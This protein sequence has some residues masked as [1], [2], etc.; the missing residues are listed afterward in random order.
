M[1]GQEAQTQA[2]FMAVASLKQGMDEINAKLDGKQTVLSIEEAIEGFSA[3]LRENKTH[4]TQ[5]S[6]RRLTHDLGAVYAGRNVPEITAQELEGFLAARWGKS[7][8]I[9]LR[10]NL[11]L[12]QRFFSWCIGYVQY[13][14]Q[15]PFVNQCSF[16]KVIG[17]KP[18]ERPEFIPV[19]KIEEFLATFKDE[20]HWL[21][22]A[23]L[24]TAGLRISELIGDPRGGKSGLRRKDV[25]GRILTI[26]KPKS[27]RDSEDAVIP[28]WVGKRL[29]KHMK[30]LHPED[31]IFSIS[32][33]S[34]HGLIKRHGRDVGLELTPH[35]LRKWCA[36]YWSRLQEY[37]MANFVLR[38]S[39]TKAVDTTLIS[40]LGARYIAPPSPVEAMERQD[41]AMTPEL[42][43]SV[44]AC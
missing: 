25:D 37:A 28:S 38:H 30:D 3:F 20:R 12:L 36:S 17:V 24:L 18:P 43:K 23:I 33:S 22:V 40:S 44:S 19:P 21:M 16:I 13:C 1:S 29:A 35:F 8:K 11:V 2:F 15:A 26:H 32:Y 7:K 41:K 27:G 6:Y 31:R 39:E 9:T 10:Q 34:V 5:R 42:L 14:G 4:N